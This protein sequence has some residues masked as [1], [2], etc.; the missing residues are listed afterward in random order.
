MHIEVG[1]ISAIL[2]LVWCKGTPCCC[3]PEPELSAIELNRKKMA[4]RKTFCS[5]TSTSGEVPVAYRERAACLLEFRA[6]TY[7]RYPPIVDIILYD[8]M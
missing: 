3:Q 8:L 1:K 2:A 6:D 7:Q 5:E 4:G